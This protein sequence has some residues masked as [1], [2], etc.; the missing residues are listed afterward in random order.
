M[1]IL[2]PDARSIGPVLLSQAQGMAPGSLS[3]DQSLLLVWPDLTA[4]F[5]LTTVCFGIAYAT[6]LRQ[7]VRTL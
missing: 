1:A 6:F 3:L 5:A 7:E 4:I 2:T